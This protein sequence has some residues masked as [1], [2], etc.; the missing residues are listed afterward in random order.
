MFRLYDVV[1]GL[2]L[3]TMKPKRKLPV[4]YYLRP[5]GRFRHLFTPKTRHDIINAI[6]AYV[7]KKWQEI[8]KLEQLTQQ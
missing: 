4:E 5:Q 2:C 7:D 6:Q 3:I 1:C 8:Q